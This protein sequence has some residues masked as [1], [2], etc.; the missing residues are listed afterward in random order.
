MIYRYSPDMDT[1]AGLYTTGSVD[2]WLAV[3]RELQES[4]RLAAQWT[5]PSYVWSHPDLD[6]HGDFPAT[7]GIECAFSHRAYE[8]LAPLI[9]DSVEQLDLDVPGG[10]LT[11]I[12]VLDLVDCLDETR[13]GIWRLPDGK[14][15]FVHKYHLDESLTKGHH[16]FRIPQTCG[17][18]VLVSEEFRDAVKVAGLKGYKF[19]EPLP[20]A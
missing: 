4:R 11:L 18:E 8:V 15:L 2:E 14:I 20:T 12:H 19:G 5:P 16:M 6:F 3:E 10:G 17:I 9:C 7:V 1:F 13:S